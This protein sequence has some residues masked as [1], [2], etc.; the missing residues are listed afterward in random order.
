MAELHEA[1]DSIPEPHRTVFDRYFFDEEDLSTIA[2]I[3]NLSEE[4][5]QTLYAEAIDMLASRLFR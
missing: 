4:R 3:Y 5:A 1:I 2:S